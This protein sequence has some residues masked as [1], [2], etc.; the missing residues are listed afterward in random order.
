MFFRVRDENFLIHIIL[1]FSKDDLWSEMSR[2]KMKMSPLDF[3]NADCQGY[4]LKLDGR[5]KC[6]KTRFC[7]LSDAFLYLYIDKES[8]SALGK[9]KILIFAVHY[10]LKIFLIIISNH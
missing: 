3:I 9:F 10:L 7:L 4:L 1:F 6:W 5:S 8:E 2:Q